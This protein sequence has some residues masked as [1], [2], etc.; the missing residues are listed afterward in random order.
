MTYLSVYAKDF[1]FVL[2]VLLFEKNFG[3][4][5]VGTQSELTIKTNLYPWHTLFGILI[6]YPLV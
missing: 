3:C 6:I 2:T 5:G 1:Y 4:G